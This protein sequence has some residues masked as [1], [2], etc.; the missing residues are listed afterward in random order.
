MTEKEFR[1]L[2]SEVEV[3]KTQKEEILVLLENIRN[4]LQ[5]H[6]TFEIVDMYRSGALSKGTMLKNTTTFD[7]V[8]VVKPILKKN[9]NLI[10]QVIVFQ[11]Y[12]DLIINNSLITKNSDVTLNLEKNLIELKINDALIKIY[13][14]YDDSNNLEIPLNLQ[15]TLE[16]KR[17]KFVEV[18]NR[19]YTYFR[20]TIQII[21]YYRDEQKINY[22]TG[23]MIEVLLYYSLCEYCFDI[24]Y[25]DYLNAFLKGLDDFI[26]GKKIEVSDKMYNELVV[27]EISSIKKGYTIIDV[28][29][30]TINLTEEINEIKV[31]EFRKLK[32]ALSKLVDTKTF[33]NNSSAVVKLNI[34]PITKEDGNI[35][36]SFKIEDTKIASNGGIYPPT[37]EEILSA[38]Y[39]ALLKGLKAIIDNNLNRSQVEIICNEKNIL[40]DKLALSNENNA[41]RKNVLAFMDNNKIKILK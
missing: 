18:A 1:K 26:N 16:E 33:I 6:D 27:K 11:I 20:N 19:D 9:F 29:S 35:S 7:F 13:I 40:S 37:K 41:R 28:A 8:I 24:R 15:N 25:E 5:K 31:M 39:K 38:M 12:T 10:N 22:I 17:I 32:K 21:K 2:V 34:N 14:Y 36:W 30:R 23:Y 4:N 3:P